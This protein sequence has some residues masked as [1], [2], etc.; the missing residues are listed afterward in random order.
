[1]PSLGPRLGDPLAWGPA[2]GL[3]LFLAPNGIRVC[4]EG[5]EPRIPGCGFPHVPRSRGTR[6]PGNVTEMQILGSW[7]RPA[8][9]GEV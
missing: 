2:W 1:M 9:S 5:G 6:L 8:E 3:L 7:P 4:S